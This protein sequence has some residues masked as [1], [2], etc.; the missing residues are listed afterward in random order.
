MNI[1]GFNCFGHDSAA[2]LIVDGKPVFALPGNPVAAQIGVFRYVLPYLNMAVAARAAPEEF[3]VLGEDV[4]I[5]TPLTYFLPVKIGS[6]PDGRLM[7]RPVF[8]NGSGDY[9]SLAGSD[10]FIE[11]PADTFRFPMGTAAR[12]YRWKF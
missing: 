7:G 12:L 2:S 3:A 9:A 4:E 1:L 11:L 10:G 8:P 6:D 5:K